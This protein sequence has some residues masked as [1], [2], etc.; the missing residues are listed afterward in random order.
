[1]VINWP[2]LN[3]KEKAELI[4]TLSTRDDW[5]LLTHPL[6]TRN[7][8]Q[9]PFGES[10]KIARANGKCSRHKWWWREAKDEL[11]THSMTTEVWINTRGQSSEPTRMAIQEALEG[12]STKDTPSFGTEDLEEIHRSGTEAGLLGIYNFPGAVYATDGSGG[13]S[14]PAL[15]EGGAAG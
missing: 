9:P 6:G 8:S 14:S 13:H 2:G 5:I 15:L 7:K 1:M 4:P 11:A 12:E 10:Q 3:D